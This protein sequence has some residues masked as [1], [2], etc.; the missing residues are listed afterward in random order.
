[1]DYLVRIA[2]RSR[3]ARIAHS[4]KGLLAGSLESGPHRWPNGVGETGHN[5]RMDDDVIDMLMNAEANM[6]LPTLY[7][8]RLWWSGGAVPPAHSAPSSKP[9]VR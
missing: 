8:D 3:V 9:S 7:L 1:M 6:D 5:D 4:R 2:D